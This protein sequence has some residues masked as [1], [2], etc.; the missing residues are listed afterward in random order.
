M[1]DEHCLGHLLQPWYTYH[2]MGKQHDS[3]EF[4][5]GLRHALYGVSREHGRP[6]SPWEAR[7]EATT[8]DL[9]LLYTPILLQ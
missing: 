3:T 8:E 5:G 7:L 1:T 2:A 6:V 9:G 4:V